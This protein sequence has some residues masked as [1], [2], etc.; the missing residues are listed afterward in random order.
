MGQLKIVEEGY[1]GI[2]EENFPA[3]YMND[4][5]VLGLV[6]DNL[7]NTFASLEENGLAVEMGEEGVTVAL[8]KKDHIHVV[9]DLLR[10]NG[11]AYT[12]SDLVRCAYQG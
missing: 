12:M 1:Q 9:L 4:F 3:F 2:V 10:E 6:V 8:G 7:G 5:S 11:I